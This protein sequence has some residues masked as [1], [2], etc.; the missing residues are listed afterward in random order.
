MTNIQKAIEKLSDHVFTAYPI[1]S[2]NLA[3]TV[4]NHESHLLKKEGYLFVFQIWPYGK[5]KD[6]VEVD[7]LLTEEENDES[8]HS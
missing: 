3:H 2:R 7:I 1:K 5:D 6:P 4:A 8:L